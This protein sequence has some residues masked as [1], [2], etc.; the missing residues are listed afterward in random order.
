MFDDVL[1]D[2]FC[3]RR[4]RRLRLEKYI[5]KQRFIDNF[6]SILWKQWKHEKP[7]IAYG[8][9]SFASTGR[10]EKAGPVNG[11]SE[12]VRDDMKHLMLTS[13]VL[14]SV[15][16]DVEVV[17]PH[18]ASTDQNFYAA[19]RDTVCWEILGMRVLI[20]VERF[21]HIH[22]YRSSYDAPVRSS[23]IANTNAIYR[24][25]LLP[26][27]LVNL[28]LNS[29]QGG[30]GGLHTKDISPDMDD[31]KTDFGGRGTFD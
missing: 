22:L 4:C 31:K 13:S 9:A 21:S 20:R 25:T 8:N 10:G 11:S 27:S 3:K 23:I 17:Y 19:A 14:P 16:V 18:L 7:I 28:P 5:G 24:H 30:V 6:F 29:A 12:N 26:V 2:Q 15:A 1:L